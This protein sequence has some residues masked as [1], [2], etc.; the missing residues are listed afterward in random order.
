MSNNN[1]AQNQNI[2]TSNQ[3]STMATATASIEPNINLISTNL[4]IVKEQAKE[5]E[6]MIHQLEDQLKHARG[7][8][9]VAEQARAAVAAA[10]ARPTP[11]KPVPQPRPQRRL[12]PKS[13]VAKVLRGNSFNTAQIAKATGLS[14]GKSAEALRALKAERKVANVGSEDFPRWTYRI[15]DETSAQELNAEVKRLI[16]DRP[17]T[18]QELIETTGARLARVSGALIALQ[19]TEK[20]LLNLGTQRRAKWFL[21]SD[22]VTLARLPPKGRPDVAS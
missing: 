18:T 21:V 20:Q 17:M 22:R 1:E 15:G 19:R 13:E 12:D 16:E 7:T 11:V 14:I 9:D 4:H 6:D 5:L 3:E 10:E 2:E 8:G